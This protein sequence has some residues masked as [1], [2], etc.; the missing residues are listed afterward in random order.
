MEN[1]IPGQ[2]AETILQNKR[3]SVVII[4]P[5]QAPV[6]KYCNKNV[7]NYNKKQTY[8]SMELI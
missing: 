5:V 4:N 1:K 6:Q 3:M 8:G 2:I 7:W